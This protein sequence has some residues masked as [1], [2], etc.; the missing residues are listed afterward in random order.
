M[1]E[2]QNTEGGE[3]EDTEKPLPLLLS[4]KALQAAWQGAAGSTVTSRAGD[5]AQALKDALQPGDISKP[6]PF[7]TMPATCLLDPESHAA[8]ISC[9]S[10]S[11][12]HKHRNLPINIGNSRSYQHSLGPPSPLSQS[13]C[14]IVP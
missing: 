8:M 7:H 13:I 2:L 9:L 3:E 11:F 5:M 10:S 4:V 14:C 6:I 12:A 1:V